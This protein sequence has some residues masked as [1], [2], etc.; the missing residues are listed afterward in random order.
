MLMMNVRTPQGQKW[1]INLKNLITYIAGKSPTF[2]QT[3]ANLDLE[4]V[5]KI[6]QDLSTFS[7]D[8]G[9]I[10]TQRGDPLTME[11]LLNIRRDA[12][13]QVIPNERTRV[14][15]ISTKFLGNATL[16]FVAQLFI[17]SARWASKN[18]STSLQAVLFIDEADIYMPARGSAATKE[19]LLNLLKRGRSAG[20]SVGLATQSPGEM[21]YQGRNNVETWFIGKI[22]ER[23]ALDKVSP[24]VAEPEFMH[25]IPF[26][27]V[28]R[29]VLVTGSVLTRL[30]GT[31]S[32]L[33][34]A[35]LSED[36]IL[37]LARSGPPSVA[38]VKAKV[39]ERKTMEG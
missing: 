32:M 9:R 38:A 28:G 18:P 10:L 12:D 39:R 22:K 13:K 17:E 23:V 26:Q 24:M 19:P 21:D 4:L 34:T 31:P 14:S 30:H 3:I 2:L 16:F 15:I 7:L 27:D 1:E 35:Q 5:Q 29:F 36:Q 20:L 11:T 37:A 25:D 33:V 8:K 6:V